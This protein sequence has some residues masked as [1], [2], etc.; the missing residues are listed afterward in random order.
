MARAA[1]ELGDQAVMYIPEMGTAGG[2]DTLGVF[3]NAENK[4]A[5]MLLVNWLLSDEAQEAATSLL[6]VIPARTDISAPD[7]GLTAEEMSHRTS[8][9]PVAYKTKFIQDFTT[10]VLGQ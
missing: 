10:Y 5:A 2:G 1:G 6:N 8:W 9:V 7:T 3:A 4:A